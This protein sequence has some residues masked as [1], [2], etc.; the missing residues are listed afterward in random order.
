MA[1]DIRHDIANRRWTVTVTH[2]GHT[3]VDHIS[4]REML[5][6]K[7]QAE[8]TRLR[9]AMAGRLYA[10]IENK[11]DREKRD[12]ADEFLIAADLCEENGFAVAASILREFGSFGA[13]CAE[14]TWNL[15]D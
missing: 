3:M 12:A 8:A 15:P 13:R 10:E 6:A 11:I 5:L 4:D 14:A 2:R 7:S 9:S 1:F